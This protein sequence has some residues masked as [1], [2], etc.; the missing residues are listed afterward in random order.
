MYTK[1]I[2]MTIEALSA[3]RAAIKQAV[4]T[5][6]LLS[7]FDFEIRIIKDIRLKIIQPNTINNKERFEMIIN[8]LILL[9]LL[10]DRRCRPDLFL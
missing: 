2:I 9:R 10:I 4:Q 1:I 6:G 8:L 5:S 3:K 7:T